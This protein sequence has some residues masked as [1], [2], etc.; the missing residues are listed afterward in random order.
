MDGDKDDECTCSSK[1][2]EGVSS[3]T[4][5]LGETNLTSISHVMTQPSQ[6]GIENR[7]LEESRKFFDQLCYFV[8]NLHRIQ[9][10]T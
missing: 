1:L 7:E 9:F 2:E 8:M 3:P 10:I 6:I 5:C 4:L